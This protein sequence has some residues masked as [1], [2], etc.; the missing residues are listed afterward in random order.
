MRLLKMMCIAHPRKGKNRKRSNPNSRMESNN[1]RRYTRSN[2][3]N[4][5][6][7]SYK[8]KNST[9]SGMVNHSRNGTRS[10]NRNSAQINMM[11]NIRNVSRRTPVQRVCM[12]LQLPMG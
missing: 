7:N 6:R 1:R 2:M 11:N 8:V 9:W 4:P 10:I 5:S 12:F 3:S